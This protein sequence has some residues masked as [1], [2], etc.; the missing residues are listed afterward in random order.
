M[1]ILILGATG[2]TGRLLA[3][4][5][6]TENHKVTAI[7]R[8]KTRATIN[9]VIYLEGSPVDGELLNHALKG[10]DAVVVSLNINRKSD[11]PFARIVSPPTL[12]SDAV[13][14]LIPA[15]KKNG[16]SRIISISAYGVGDSWK[17]MPLIGRWF[18]SLGN[19]KKAYDDHDRQERVLRESGLDWTIVRPVMLND[20]VSG[21]YTATN[22]KPSSGKISRMAVARFILDALESG[23][24][25]QQV[26]SLSR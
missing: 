17:E 22:G 21:K 6:I 15:M 1:N 12:I 16:V 20:E 9:E 5:A 19:I 13:K 2:R 7:I 23:E 3:R 4:E 11:S 26:V 8:D 14:A 18:I 10:K 24:Y 25:I